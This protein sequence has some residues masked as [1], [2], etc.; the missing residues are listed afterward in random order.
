MQES[1]A[2]CL[3]L[4]EFAWHETCLTLN[5]SVNYLFVQNAQSR[6]LDCHAKDANTEVG[7]VDLPT[8]TKEKKR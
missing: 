6:R 8:Q 3:Y 4:P 5:Y 2:L 7:T 1:S